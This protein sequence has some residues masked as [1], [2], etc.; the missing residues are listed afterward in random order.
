M[1]SRKVWLIGIEVAFLIMCF[2]FGTAHSQ[3]L[4]GW[5]GKWF[6]LTSSH[7]GY[8]TFEDP[9]HI[10]NTLNGKTPMYLKIT[11]WDTSNPS[12]KILECSGYEQDEEGGISQNTMDLHY[13]GGTDL[14]FLVLCHVVSGARIGFTARVTGRE[15]AG[16]LKSASFKT[17]GGY[18]WERDSDPI[19]NPRNSEAGGLTIT[20]NLISVSKLP[21]WVPQ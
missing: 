4:S 14:D 3:D 11:A 19:S 8:E 21:A 12:D 20:G 2:T 18:I 5:V 15:S 10:P 17:L 9:D 16:T 6:K 7:K 13:L 1:K